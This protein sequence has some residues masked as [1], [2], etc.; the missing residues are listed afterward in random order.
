MRSRTCIASQVWVAAAVAVVLAGCQKPS[1][2]DRLEKLPTLPPEIAA[3]LDPKTNATK[4]P[5][6]PPVPVRDPSAQAAPCCG[7]RDARALKVRVPLTKCG[8][9]KDF[10]LAPITDLVMAA[11]APG[12]G[13][14]PGGAAAGASD[15][16]AYKLTT[17]NHAS[18]FD[19]IICMTSDGPWDAL[20]TEERNCNGYMP[21]D[22]LVI[23]G[24]AGLV[25]YVWNGGVSNHP[26]EVHPVSCR[27]IGVSR[28]PC[29]G[30]SSCQC[31]S[32]SCPAGQECNC[33]LPW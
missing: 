33:A 29:G 32:S 8:R 18:V 6:A 19:T 1:L 26:P 22:S 2:E 21:I 15:V 12:G 9:F 24:W 25:S 4:L 30:P 11:P 20:F 31:Q 7:S 3:T 13:A 17:V 27:E 5:A 28:F 16:R 14:A 10:M 23:S